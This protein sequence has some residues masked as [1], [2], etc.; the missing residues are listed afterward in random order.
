MT[1][2][3]IVLRN[4]I[5]TRNSNN[6]NSESQANNQHTFVFGDYHH[7]VPFNWA[8]IL[9]YGNFKVGVKCFSKKGYSTRFP[10]SDYCCF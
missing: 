1:P 2:Q 9:H 8:L 6:K 4:E 10:H 5:Q 3:R 7:I